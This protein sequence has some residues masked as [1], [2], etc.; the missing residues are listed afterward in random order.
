MDDADDADP[1]RIHLE[2]DLARDATQQHAPQPTANHRRTLGC[3]DTL[4]QRGVDLGHEVG[5]SVTRSG[6]TPLER[7]RN[8][9]AGLGPDAEEG[10]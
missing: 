9:G 2:V 7:L 5:R 10:H 4:T 1:G 3:V 6:E 8:L